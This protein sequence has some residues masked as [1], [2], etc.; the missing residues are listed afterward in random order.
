MDIK[1][2]E[3]TYEETM[4]DLSELSL[5]ELRELV[6]EKRDILD[7]IEYSLAI[8]KA[9]GNLSK[10]IDLQ[11]RFGERWLEDYQDRFWDNLLAK[12]SQKDFQENISDFQEHIKNIEGVHEVE[13]LLDNFYEKF[14]WLQEDW[15]IM[16]LWDNLSNEEIFDKEALTDFI[17]VLDDY[18]DYL[19]CG[20]L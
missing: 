8:Q 19:T 6:Q 15:L 10:V 20:E 2:L 17:E 12:K 5:N 13:N 3:E 14:K 16:T 18:K 7:D 9:S 1:E 4:K 11:N